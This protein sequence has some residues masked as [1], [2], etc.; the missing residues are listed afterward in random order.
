M[1]YVWGLTS[2]AGLR[3]VSWL[4]AYYTDT[5]FCFDVRKQPGVRGHVA[6]TIDDGLCRQ[7]DAG[8]SMADEVGDLL[9]QHGANAT[10]FVCS[11]Y[12]REPRLE[13]QARR[14][15]ADGNELGNHCAKDREYASLSADD[16]GQVFS[17]A[18]GTLTALLGEGDRV[19]WFRAPQGRYTRAMRDSVER[20]GMQHALG[21]A[22]CDDWM[23]GS[24]P[25]WIARTLLNQLRDGSIVIIHMPVGR[26]FRQW[27]YRALQLLLEGLAARGLRA[28]TLSR[29]AS[30]AEQESAAVSSPPPYR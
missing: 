19:R 20:A 24:D 22:Y 23:Q 29:L 17:E 27:L 21:D 11:D 6:L 1:Q 30:L 9:K 4:S 3:P 12:V 7:R 18:N 28:V 25:E 14:L 8:Q 13:G 16:F 15:V 26:G 5:Y 2:K 10:F